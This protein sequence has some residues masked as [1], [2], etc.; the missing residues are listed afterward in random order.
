M[1]MLGEV[2]TDPL[3]MEHQGSVPGLG[4][5]PIRTVMKA[6]KVTHNTTGKMAVK[7]LFGQRVEDVAVSGYEIHIGQTLY[8]DDAAPFAYLSA[9]PLSSGVRKDGCI[10][11]DARIFGTY[12]H[13]LFDDDGFRH[14]FLRAGRAFRQLAAPRKLVLWKQSREES[15]NRLA[16]EVEKSLDMKTIFSWAGLPYEGTATAGALDRSK[17]SRQKDTGDEQ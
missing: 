6:D 11:R 15:M 1:Q 5:L 13:G 4:L 10:N 17:Y 16:Y 3:G 14:Q 7:I 2:I 9:G 8:A 12:L